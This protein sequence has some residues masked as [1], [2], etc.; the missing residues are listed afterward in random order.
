MILSS[1]PDRLVLATVLC[2][3]L[4]LVGPC[5]PFVR[6]VVQQ[7]HHQQKKT[8][9]A[10]AA[11]YYCRRQ[12]NPQQLG[13]SLTGRWC[14]SLRRRTWEYAQHA[15][16]R[17]AALWAEQPPYY[18]GEGSTSSRKNIVDP[19]ATAKNNT[20]GGA[21]GEKEENTRQPPQEDAPIA[22]AVAAAEENS[23]IHLSNN[24]NDNSK[25]MKAAA[26]TTI[27]ST[28]VSVL[29]LNLV[30]ILW[31]SQHAVIK[32]V[33]SDTN[34]PAAFT[35]LRFGLAAL[36]ASPYTPSLFVVGSSDDSSSAKQ[37]QNADAWRWGLEMGFWMFLGFGFQAIGLEYTTAQRSGFLLYLNVKFVPFL[38]FVLLGRQISAA[39]WASALT[40]FTGTALLAMQPDAGAGGGAGSLDLNVGDWWTI[41]AA[42]ASAMFIL[43]LERASTVVSDAAALN[44]ACLWVVTLLSAAW[45]V[46]QLYFS[47]EN[48]G[49]GDAASLLA[50]ATPIESLGSELM[51]I[52]TTHPLELIYLGAVTTAFCNWL[53]TKAQRNITAE[54]ASVIYAM[55][56]VYGAGFAYL[57]LG[58]TLN[59]A[60][61][62]LGAGLITV[63]AATNA[64]LD[65]SNTVKE[66]EDHLPELLN[67]DK[68]LSSLDEKEKVEVDSSR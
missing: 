27:S 34:N 29:L 25:A 11:I 33:V 6:R 53:Q 46:A 43:R 65:V 22:A 12:T 51:H 9:P 60:T 68:I 40:A 2:G 19:S 42:A 16:S 58:E 48:A 56:P 62:W 52:A 1:Q 28:T 23:A 20:N 15:I 54:R 26:T 55:D 21:V 24:D 32:T 66:E 45:T 57:L 59:S 17:P 38:A 49:S 10:A 44:A 63:A 31:G 14:P 50:S 18:G 3:C 61:S 41:A 47:V 8:S 39:T 67:G 4:F 5:H 30:A 37:N 64:F 35:L 36:L 13:T 7:Q